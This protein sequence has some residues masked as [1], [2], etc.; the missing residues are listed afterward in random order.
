[1][2]DY[3]ARYESSEISGAPVTFC[4]VCGLPVSESIYLT[5]GRGSS[6]AVDDRLLRVCGACFSEIEG[7]KIEVFAEGA[8]SLEF[9]GGT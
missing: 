3:E 1:M 7:G 8:E 2:Y 6:P 5:S 9:E 4:D